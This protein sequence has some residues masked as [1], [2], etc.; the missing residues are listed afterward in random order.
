VISIIVC[1]K[2][3]SR[4]QPLRDNILSKIGDIIYELIIID[5]SSNNYSIF[6][7]YNKGVNQSNYEK[8]LFIHDDIL[9]HTPKFGEVILN[10]TLPNLGVLGIA[11]AKLKTQVTSPWWITNYDQVPDGVLFQS[12][13]QKYTSTNSQL[14]NL[15]FTYDNQIEEVLLVDGVFL[16]TTKENCLHNP[17]DEN[18]CS[19]H[20]YDL[21][22][23]LSMHKFGKKN[24][25]T[26]AILIEHFSSG[27]LNKDW[28]EAS[29][30]YQ[31]KW[32]NALTV[33]QNTN[34]SLEKLAYESRVQIL[35][36]N[37]F[38]LK[39]F[40]SMFRIDFLSMKLFLV[41]FKSIV[42]G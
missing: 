16:Y 13:I 19:F 12:N 24:Y 38:Y 37:K 9:F 42:R 15:G 7:A 20:F 39:T 33:S 31:K 29:F 32:G 26:N 21:D 23:S 35:L 18:Y 22:F 1:N 17:F 27:S 34:K 14:V 11:G 25:V 10:L 8:L 4:I 41:V 28:V 3:K 30:K 2:D 36:K 40:Q 5:N 6:E